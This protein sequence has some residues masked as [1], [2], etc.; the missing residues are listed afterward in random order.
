MRPT[1][2]SA[3]IGLSQF[4]DFDKLKFLRNLNRNKII[5]KLKS[6]NK[7]SKNLTFIEPNNL[8]FPSW[9]SIPILLKTKIKKL[10]IKKIEQKGIE[11]R[12]IISGNFL[13]QPAIMKYKLKNKEKFPCADL[14]NDCGFY[15]YT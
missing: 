2:I 12:P 11:T 3:A 5:N 8:V 6:N 14:I 10:F 4:N 1:D 7:I 9:F 15:Q 13:K